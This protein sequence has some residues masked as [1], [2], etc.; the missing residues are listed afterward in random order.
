MAEKNLTTNNNSATT[1]TV[2]TPNAKPTVSQIIGT[3][4]DT[5]IRQCTYLTDEN[6]CSS[7]LFVELNN[8]ID[9]ENSIKPKGKKFKPLN[10]LPAI[11]I[12]ML[13]AARDDVALIA[14]GDKSQQGYLKDFSIAERAKLPLAFYQK[15]GKNTGVWEIENTM[16]GNFSLLVES[17]KPTVTLREKKEIYNYVR[18]R[19]QVVE[20][21]MIPHYVAVGNS[22]VDVLNK[23]LLPFSPDLV[24]TSK[25][26]TNLNLAAT[27]PFITIPEDGSVWD[28]DSWIASLGSAD[29]VHSIKEV[30]QAACLPLAP[31][32][33]MVLFYNTSGN[34]G[35][36]TICQ[37]IRNLLG[38][39]VTASIKL[40]DFSSPFGLA[41]LPKSVAVIVDEND[42]GLFIKNLSVVKAV[43]TGD[44]V[45]INQKYEKAYDYS[46]HGLVLECINEYM[47][48]QDK[49]GS[50]KRRLFIIPFPCCF[51]GIEKKYI[52]ERLVY[53]KDVLEYVLKTVLITMDYR[54]T[55]TET[56]ES[57]AAL[58]EYESYTNTVVAFLDEFLP[59]ARWNLLPATELLYE[60]YKVWYRNVSPSGNLIGRNDFIDSLKNYVLMETKENPQFPW[61]WTDSTRSKNYIDLKVSEPIAKEFGID[62][63]LRA[64]GC[65]NYYSH[66][67]KEKYSGLKRR[68]FVVPNDNDK[69]D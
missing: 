8:A 42:V 3:T 35:K 19:V 25:I 63:F 15:Y 37:L 49:S 7:E 56:A 59:T 11:S 43:I 68:N 57:K 31:R 17:Y 36:G 69:E 24:F 33:K 21:C 5:F 50:F 23:K 38:E 58:Y 45:T 1:N 47:R 51:N 12:A 64:G 22:I 18:N 10:D 54:D 14:D 2:A 39:D 6:R 44:V 16:E 55:F 62:P 27:N 20:K 26:Q 28:F 65:G 48:V 52:K 60:A 67:I 34:G 29:F 30:I 4:T 41:N 9:L 13:I 66:L 61:E 40:N 46:F 32:N 53:R